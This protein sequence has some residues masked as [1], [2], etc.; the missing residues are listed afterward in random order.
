M[1]SIDDLLGPSRT[2]IILYELQPGSGHWTAVFERPNG[3]IE[4]YDSLGYVPDS[5][6]GFIPAEFRKESAQNHTHLLNLLANT[7]NRIEYNE[8]P[9][10][11]DERGI[12]SCGRWC[13][14]RIANRDMS[15]KQFQNFVK[16]HKIDDV[17]VSLIVPNS[18]LDAR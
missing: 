7:K 18:P 15:I 14:F 9:L 5:E 1:G 4:C 8:K 2:A 10:Q 13:I 6:I 12:S 17:K 3:T 16:K 11:K